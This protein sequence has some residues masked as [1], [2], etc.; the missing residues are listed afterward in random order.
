MHHISVYRFV[1][2]EKN[3]FHCLTM[4]KIH[5][6]SKHRTLK[7]DGEI[8]DTG[9][10]WKPALVSSN[11]VTTLTGM[12]RDFLKYPICQKCKDVG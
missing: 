3:M 8:R 7:S 12:G 1:D 2:Q 5:F 9:E 4:S 11:I 6:S 10:I